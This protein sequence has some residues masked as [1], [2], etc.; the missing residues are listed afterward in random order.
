MT[1]LF[2]IVDRSGSMAGLEKATIDGYN[3]YVDKLRG[4]KVKI[5][6]V[7]FDHEFITL[8]DSKA[9][10]DSPKLDNE[11]YQPRGS[12]ALIDAVCR[13]INSSKDTVKKSDKALVLV[14]TDGYEN[15]SRENKTKD[16]Q[17][18]VQGL[19]KKGNWTFT[20]LGANQD[21]WAT[22]QDWGFQQG[23]VANFNATGKGVGK[24]F[25]MSA[26]NTQ[27]FS[28]G[29]SMSATD[30]YSDEDKETLKDAK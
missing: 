25:A 18:L 4:E 29:S 10:K 7:L 27:N 14:I 13:T 8:V 20:Y 21:A 17:E 30:F 19:E 24:V 6:T 9:I 1:H 3:E 28:R 16:M 23:N 26:A 22:A 12:T 15:A 2:C 5:T 11:T